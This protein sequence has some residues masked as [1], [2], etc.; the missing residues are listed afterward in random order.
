LLLL[1]SICAVTGIPQGRG[2]AMTKIWEPQHAAV[3]MAAVAT[4]IALMVL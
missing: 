2:P 3:F 1:W 4:I